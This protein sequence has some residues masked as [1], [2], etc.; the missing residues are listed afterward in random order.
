MDGEDFADLENRLWSAADEL[1]ANS[2]LRASEF[3]T[4]V[5]G[6]IFLRYA[7]H[8]F[9]ETEEEL[10]GKVTGR[11]QIGKADYQSRGILFLPQEARFRSLLDLP[12]GAD[13]GQ[14]LNEAMRAIEAENPDLKDVLPKTYNRLENET[15]VELLKIMNSI[16][17][18]MEGDAFG[19]IYE[20]FLGQFAMTEGQKGGEFYTPMSIVQLIVNIIEPYKGR[21]LDPA[22]G[23]GGMF[24]QSARFVEEHRNNGDGEL[25]IYGQERVGDTV[26]L[27]K[28]N[29]AVHGL[30]GDIRQGNTYYE[31][32]YMDAS[33]GKD[34]DYV[35]A[36]PPFNVDRVDKER[37]SDDERFIHGLPSVD[38]ANYL[39]MQI[40]E[41][42]LNDGGRAGYVM[43]NS[44][45][46]ARHSEREIRRKMIE[47]GVVDVLVAISSNFFYTVSLPC[48]LWFLDKGKLGTEREDKVLFID[49]R[50]IYRQVNRTLRDFKPA[51]IE[52][53]G[54]IVRLYRGSEPDNIYQSDELMSE[55]FPGG[56]YKDVPGLCKVVTRDEIEEQGW[57]LN[58]GRYVGIEQGEEP[59]DYEFETK[60][61]ELYEELSL[62]NSKAYDLEDQI[63]NISDGILGTE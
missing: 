31:P 24:V 58:P 9:T 6:L 1:R 32:L 38:N 63:Q 3:S 20:Y 57:S 10:E 41:S 29:L 52:F 54:N 2:K 25:S 36:N 26:R 5:L 53:L 51:Q 60:F 17:M 15:L 55:H 59:I 61:G 19:R 39:W 33:D 27:C 49:A 21:I 7:D 13:I 48:T 22:C 40:F 4:P 35:M 34:F 42:A 8:R 18:D 23:S 37:L 47:K 46:D 28:M 56:N 11:R 43:A 50:D 45:N 30:A 44:A 16:P 12:E 14:E 62:L